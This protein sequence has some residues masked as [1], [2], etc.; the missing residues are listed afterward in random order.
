VSR[1][2]L[3]PVY[4][5]PIMVQAGYSC[6]SRDLDVFYGSDQ[7]YVFVGSYL[8]PVHPWFVRGTLWFSFDL[9]F[10]YFSALFLITFWV[11]F[12]RRSLGPLF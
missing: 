7:S 11:L 8:W 1:K 2:F 6:R 10:D 4:G 5:L 9:F 3:P 12:Q